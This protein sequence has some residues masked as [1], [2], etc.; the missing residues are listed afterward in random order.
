MSSLYDDLYKKASSVKQ[1]LKDN[2]E[3]YKK[4]I[5]FAENFAYAD[6][7]WMEVVLVDKWKDDKGKERL[8]FTDGKAIEFAISKNRFE[9]LK[10]SELGQ[11]LKFKLH[12]QEIKKEVENRFSWLGKNIITEYKHIPLIAEK[13]EKQHW[14]ILEDTFAIVDYI[15]KEKTSFTQLLQITKKSFSRK[16]KVNYKLE[17][18][19]QQRFT[20][21]K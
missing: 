4:F 5:P 6:F 3:L 13:S 9:V 17:I 12:K 16:S 19:L 20:L 15:N 7:H 14:E 11:I 10:Q 1:S 21:K 18:S 2:R 8:T